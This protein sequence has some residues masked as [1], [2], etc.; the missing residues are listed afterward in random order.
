LMQSSNAPA[1]G[2]R[3]QL[4]HERPG[5]RHPAQTPVRKTDTVATSR[6]GKDRPEGPKGGN[7]AAVEDRARASLAQAIESS[8]WSSG[9]PSNPCT[10]FDRRKGDQHIHRRAGKL[11]AP[12]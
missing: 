6:A 1:S 2:D 7:V 4:R 9:D 10:R 12:I 11:I 5:D 3:T 8:S